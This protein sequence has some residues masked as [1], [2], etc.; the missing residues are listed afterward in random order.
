M[1]LDL[2]WNNLNNDG[3]ATV[4]TGYSY[5]ISGSSAYEYAALPTNAYLHFN[6]SHA[7]ASS[8]AA[9]STTL[10]V[11]AV[12]LKSDCTPSSLDLSGGLDLGTSGDD[13]IVELG[14]G[15]ISAYGELH[16]RDVFASI[17]GTSSM[18]AGRWE[19]TVIIDTQYPYNIEIH[20]HVYLRPSGG[21]GISL[22]GYSGYPTINVLSNSSLTVQRDGWSYAPD[23]PDPGEAVIGV[24][25]DGFPLQSTPCAGK[26]IV[27]YD[28]AFPGSLYMPD[29]FTVDTLELYI[30]LGTADSTLDFA[31][32]FF[33]S[34]QYIVN[35]Y[36][37]YNILNITFST[38]QSGTNIDFKGKLF[39]RPDDGVSLDGSDLGSWS[40][41]PGYTD[42]CEV[43]FNE[44]DVTMLNLYFRNGLS[45]GN[46]IATRNGTMRTANISVG[47]GVDWTNG[48]GAPAIELG[49][50]SASPFSIYGGNI[51]VEIGPIRIFDEY[52]NLFRIATGGGGFKTADLTVDGGIVEPV[53]LVEV[54][55]AF[56]HN[57][58]EAFGSPTSLS[59]F[60]VTGE[61]LF[62]YP[63]PL[64]NLDARQGS[65]LRCQAGGAYVPKW[66]L[67]VYNSDLQ[68]FPS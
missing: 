68:R 12:Y 55:G 30:A 3:D 64:Q 40:F 20:D 39:V 48:S 10:T 54:S 5:D 37:N 24:A 33:T 53:G 11:G 22:G 27:Y 21:G 29:Y 50:G 38:D 19:N 60:R 47:S 17:Y 15:N 34:A 63:A 1:L 6:G 41:E 31:P 56:N 49:W 44:A 7:Y 61:A 57:T 52:G 18:P 13:V 26:V 46:V 32:S 28:S 16:I 8:P 36:D 45:T 2:Y 51:N 4:G 14:F 62:N 43:D 35:N 66:E 23:S 59:D 58:P 67:P 42:D 65:M 25:T 9:A